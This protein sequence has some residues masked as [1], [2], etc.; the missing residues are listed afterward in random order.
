MLEEANAIGTAANYALMLPAEHRAPVLSL[1]RTYTDVRI[2][3]GAP[4]DDAR[5]ARDIA[6]VRSASATD[7]VASGAG[8]AGRAPVAARRTASW[9]R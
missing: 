7:V 5:F 8:D 3:L 9:P 2:G 1:L 6:T 4:F